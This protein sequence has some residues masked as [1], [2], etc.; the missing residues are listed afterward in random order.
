[1]AGLSFTNHLQTVLLFPTFLLLWIARRNVWR[2]GFR[3]FLTAVLLFLLGLSLYLYLP[4]RSSNG[5]LMD[6]GATSQFDNF[7]RHISGW[8]YRVWMFNLTADRVGQNFLSA[9]E[10][11]AGQFHFLL[12]PLVL[13]GLLRPKRISPVFLWGILLFAAA[14]IFYNINYDIGEIDVYYLPAALA[15]FLFAGT[16]ALSLAEKIE[17]MKKGKGTALTALSAGLIF[18]S[19]HPLVSGWARADRTQNRFAQETVE[20]IFKSAPSGGLVFSALWDHYAPWM[21]N[22]FILKNR[23]DLTLFDLLLARYSWYLDYFKKNFPQLAAGSEREIDSARVL[24]HNFEQGKPFDPAVIEAAY[25][26]MLG[27][28]LQ[29]NAGRMPVYLD[30]ATRFDSAARWV[31]IPEGVL[32]RLYPKLGYYPFQT[33]ALGF[34][35]AENRLFWS[36]PIVRR[37]VE[38][39]NRMLQL[40]GSYEKAAGALKSDAEGR[41]FRP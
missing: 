30:A 19:A 9:V 27:S 5:P 13:A 35:E 36:D 18:L 15:F 24:I 1:L 22:H 28:L 10:T 29:N 20:N 40:R 8:Q 3:T 31:P 38:A 16:G 14:T 6:W 7:V 25:Q 39:L 2:I 33:P 11:I 37:E 21:Y 26:R 41:G 32:F 23:L 34:R 17:A 4:I 12:W